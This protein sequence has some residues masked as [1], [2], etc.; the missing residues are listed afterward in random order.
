MLSAAITPPGS[1][2][3]PIS[4]NRRRLLARIHCIRRD[5]GWNEDEYRDILQARTGQRSAADLDFVALTQVVTQLARLVRRPANGQPATRPKANDWSFIDRAAAEKR[6]LLRKIFATCRALGA[7]RSYA[8]GVARRQSKGLPRRLEMMSYE[9]LHKV[10][11]AL[12]NTQRSKAAQAA[13][14]GQP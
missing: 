9:E 11:A 6:P 13:G 5:A 4:D 1:G 7:G 2:R 3:P 14:E 8:E 10:A 12:A